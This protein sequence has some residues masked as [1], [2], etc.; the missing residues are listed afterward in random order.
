MGDSMRWMLAG[1]CALALVACSSSVVRTPAPRGGAV[2]QA[3]K[4]RPGATLVVQRGDTL[5]S[6]ATR[7][8]ITVLDL[9]TWNALAP[10]Y[11]IYPGQRL[12]LYPGGRSTPPVAATPSRPR[13]T[14]AKPPVRSSPAPTPVP[15]T[16][17]SSGFPWRWPADGSLIG[18]Y[19]AGEPTRQ[20]IDIAV[21]AGAP[22]R[23]A[24]DG[25]VV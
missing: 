11:T 23:A 25:T 1:P 9:A 5:Y 15:T 6:I 18:R 10:P 22:V 16:P 4:P 24:A 19:V 20:G 12:R 3:S 8:G 21:N 17:A 7:N 14:P 2:V 13:A